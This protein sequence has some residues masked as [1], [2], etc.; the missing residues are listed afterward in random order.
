MCLSTSTKLLCL[1]LENEAVSELRVW[2]RAP[3]FGL[4]GPPVIR[5]KPELHQRDVGMETWR[6][7]ADA[8]QEDHELF[9]AVSILHGE[10]EAGGHPG[11]GSR[12]LA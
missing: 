6:E 2:T 1:Y 3:G 9:A 7:V 11:R 4:A 5:E 12:H 10:A 8:E